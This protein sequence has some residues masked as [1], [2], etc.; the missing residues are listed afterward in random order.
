M[1]GGGGSPRFPAAPR[2]RDAAGIR[3]A[4]AFGFGFGHGVPRDRGPRRVA[5]G[6][7]SV[8]ADGGG[9]PRSRCCPAR[10][11]RAV[12]TDEIE[13]PWTRTPDAPPRAT[14]RGGTSDETRTD[15]RLRRPS[16]QGLSRQ[17]Q[18]F[19]RSSVRAGIEM[20]PCQTSPSFIARSNSS[21]RPGPDSVPTQWP[22]GPLAVWAARMGPPCA[23]TAEHTTI[24]AAWRIMS[25]SPGCRIV[26]PC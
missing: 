24:N 13:P 15:P 1:F 18:Q 12:A 10:A 4:T 19:E 8:G 20:V 14:A 3:P 6:Q 2:V 26:T 17:T 11:F 21:V 23:K 9:E 5:C 16:W 7:P 22:E 25:P